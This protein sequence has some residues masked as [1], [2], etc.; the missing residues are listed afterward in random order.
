MAFVLQ[1]MLLG[2]RVNVQYQARKLVN[3]EAQ[4]AAKKFKKPGKRKVRAATL[5]QPA[6]LQQVPSC[7]SD[8][9]DVALVRHYEKKSGGRWPGQQLVKTQNWSII[10]ISAIVGAISVLLFA[11]ALSSFAVIMF[12]QAIAVVTAYL[13]CDDAWNREHEGIASIAVIIGKMMLQ[14]KEND[15]A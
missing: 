15:V 11:P 9:E 1:I 4:K 6:I 14:Y 2:S 8:D 10:P 3:R 12:L 13:C 5:A 7:E